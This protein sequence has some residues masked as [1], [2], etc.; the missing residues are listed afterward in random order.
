MKVTLWFIRET[1]KARYYSKI[2]PAR[3]PGPEDCLWIPRSVCSH[4]SKQPD[5]MHI[6]DVDDW[7]AEKEKL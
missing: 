4:T 3:N 7:F 1:D 6:V 5:G 2:P